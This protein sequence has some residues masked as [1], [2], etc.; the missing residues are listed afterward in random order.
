MCEWL[1]AGQYNRQY[2]TGVHSQCAYAAGVLNVLAPFGGLEAYRAGVA[3]KYLLRI[4]EKNVVGSN[5]V[6][7]TVAEPVEILLGFNNTNVFRYDILIVHPYR[8]FSAMGS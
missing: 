7:P 3:V 2:D 8:H 6:M 5:Y 1:I 4:R